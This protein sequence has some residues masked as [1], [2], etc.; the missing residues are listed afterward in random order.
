MYSQIRRYISPLMYVASH[1]SVLVSVLDNLL[2]HYLLLRH[3]ELL[4]GWRKCLACMEM[5]S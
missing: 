1:I 2:L 3:E 5:G 4:G